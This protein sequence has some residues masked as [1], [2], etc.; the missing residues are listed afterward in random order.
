MNV[1]V[2]DLMARQVVTA[3]P[4]HTA[5]HVGRLM[6]RNHV[7]AI[8]IVDT[9]KRPIGIVSRTDLTETVKNGTPVNHFMTERV[10]TVPRYEDASIAARVMR[11]QKIHR[12]IVTEDQKVV[13]VLS[14]FDLLA[15]VEEHRFVMKNP[16]TPAKRHANR[17]R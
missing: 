14:A 3:E 9:Q 1:T 10:F 15:L 17:R 12:V 8:P 2:D 5:A 7:H 4:H 16:P 13:G 11:N 6:D